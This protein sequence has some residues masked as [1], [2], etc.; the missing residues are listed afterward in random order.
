MLNLRNS[1]TSA[2]DELREKTAE[3]KN[4]IK[5]RSQRSI[6]DQIEALHK[7]VDEDTDHW[8]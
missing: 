6:D 2:D 7:N 3:L 8:M 5:E 4:I 1:K